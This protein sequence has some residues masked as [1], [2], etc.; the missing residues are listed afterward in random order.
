[1][2]LSIPSIDAEIAKLPKCA[3]RG[4]YIQY[5]KYP[6]VVARVLTI[7]KA[8]RRGD[9]KKIS[10]Q[11]NFKVRTLYEWR[12]SILKNPDFNPLNK[13]TNESRRIFTEEEE[14][15]ISDYIISEIL[16]QGILFTDEDFEQL[17]MDAFLE[18]HMNDPEDSPLP[19]FQASKGF[20]YDFKKNHRLS[21][22]KCH[23]KRRPD[24]K[25]YDEK[26][27]QSIEWLFANVDPTYIINVDET[28]WE[29]VPNHLRVWH[30]T[31]ADHVLRYVN[32]N[33]KD[34]L[35]VVAGIRS[36]GTKLPL[37]FI[38]KGKTPSVLDSQIGDVG[39]HIKTY[40]ENGWTTEDTFIEFLINVRNQYLD[41]DDHT[42][43]IILDVFRAHITDKVY[44]TAKELNIKFYL[45]PAGMTDDLQ[46]LDRKI[47]GPLK[48]FA[49]KL[50]SNR[51][52]DEPAMKRT[53]IDAC[54]DMVRSWERITSE[55]IRESFEHFLDQDYWK[56]E[57]DNGGI[58][59]W[60]HHL[61]Y[62]RL[63]AAQRKM[64]REERA[65]SDV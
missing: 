31:G 48:R 8:N 56:A 36:D 1:M 39:D 13:H 32:A 21:S 27:Q 58:K 30:P 41:D 40:S 59:L 3:K 24:N 25:K 44:Q 42:I 2:A 17:I 63:T 43:H 51:Y 49:S 35:T 18:K 57:S 10:A 50:F 38:A 53:K 34:R 23:T 52:R 4:P 64:L 45:I 33:E 7:L 60:E 5:H 14:D 65:R 6:D 26:F 61:S 47:F 28:S 20:I 46:P 62:T 15:A 54:Q 55:Q 9:I 29:V 16:M 19:Q 22:R 11:T 37:Q 12:D